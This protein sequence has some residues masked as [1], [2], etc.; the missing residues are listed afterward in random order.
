MTQ[1]NAATRRTLSHK[2]STKIPVLQMSGADTS[3]TGGFTKEQ[4]KSATFSQAQEI[5]IS[6]GQILTDSSSSGQPLTSEAREILK[7]LLSHSDGARG[8]Y[9]TTLT[10]P[11]CERAFSP[12]NIRQELVE[13]IV[14]APEPNIKLLSMN[15]A[16]STATELAH[17]ANGN[18]DFAAGSRTTRERT[19]A[20]IKTVL[21]RMPQLKSELQIL[22][23]AADGAKVD[24]EG[25]VAEYKSFCDRWG[26]SENQRK[27]IVEQI[28]AVLE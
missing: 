3:T 23:F 25:K 11:E 12:S 19:K 13:A 26:Y 28:Q 20:L 27:S 10:L 6:L 4:A 14:A 21:P 8:F 24:G 18:D 2:L 9:V 7:V 22:M 1:R 16:M 5:G 17:K 15:L